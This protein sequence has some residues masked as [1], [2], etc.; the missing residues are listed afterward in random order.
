ME[1]PGSSRLS[2]R[3]HGDSVGEPGEPAAVGAFVRAL[4]ALVFDRGVLVVLGALVVDRG[5]LVV[6]CLRFREESLSCVAA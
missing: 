3:G 4:G 2:W 6:L 1:V 5:A